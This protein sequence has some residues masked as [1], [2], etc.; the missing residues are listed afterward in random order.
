MCSYNPSRIFQ[1]VQ[2]IKKRE[3]VTEWMTISLFHGYR[4]FLQDMS[5]NFSVQAF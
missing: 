3:I 2:P 1:R 4:A 5:F